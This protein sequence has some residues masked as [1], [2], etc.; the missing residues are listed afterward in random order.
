MQIPSEIAPNSI[1][2]I[3]IDESDASER[4]DK[5]LSKKFER[6]SRSFIQEL[7]KKG[8][9]EVNGKKINKSSVILKKEDKVT[10]RFPQIRTSQEALPLPQEDMGIKVIYE[11]KDFLIVYKPPHL[12]VHSPHHLDQTVTLVDWLLHH[13]KDIKGVGYEDRPGIVHR[14]DKDTSG[15]LVIPRN[16]YSHRIFADFFKNRQIEKT[17]LAIVK[18]YPPKEGTIDFKISRDTVARHKMTHKQQHGREAITHYKV[19]EYLKDSAL[20]EV[21]PQ[22]GRTHQIRVHLSAIGHPIFGD[23]TYGEKSNLIPRQALHAY[24][25]SFIYQNEIYTFWV[26]MPLDMYNLLKSLKN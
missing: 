9:I 7:I 15:I 8:C 6:Y 12:I 1:I 14:L 5:F 17:Y 4:L 18:G 16:D 22:T 19:L 2:D 11:H 3:I 20:L 25:L 26:N 10:I 24:K 13:F 21:Y 23:A